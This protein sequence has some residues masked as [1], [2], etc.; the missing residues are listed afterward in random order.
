MEKV[1][2]AIDNI[3]ARQG[4]FVASRISIIL[5]SGDIMGLV[6][7]SGSGKSTILK[8]ILGI[9]PLK[10]GSLKASVDEK[11]VELRSVLGYSSQGNALFPFLTVD[12]N[13]HFFARINGV[14]QNLIK[15]RADTLLDRLDLVN[16][17]MKR[18][19][20]LSGGMA[21]R[22]D[23]AVCLIHDPKIILMD[24]PFSGLDISLQRFFWTFLQEL[25]AKGKIIIVSSH[26]LN[27]IRRYCNEFGLI[28]DGIFYNTEQVKEELVSNKELNLEVFLE[29]LFSSQIKI[30]MEST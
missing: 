3:S 29:K 27:D 13:L 14:G 8:A 11:Q 16:S 28:N 25:A 6:G 24:E 19:S 4:S 30:N 10:S 12:E 7:R 21:K 9:L 22:V 20:Q 2:L 1:R 15:L 17:R 26:L 5:E 18:I 23:L